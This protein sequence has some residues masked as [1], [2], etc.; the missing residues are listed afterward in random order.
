L[1]KSLAEQTFPDNAFELVY[2]D[3]LWE[4]REAEVKA[5]LMGSGLNWVYVRDKPT[6]PGPCPAGARNACVERSH[7]DWII[8]IDDLTYLPKDLIERHVA[9]M[10]EG[11]DAVCGS[12]LTLKEDA[13]SRHD[14][15]WERESIK[16][17]DLRVTGAGGA[18]E[19]SDQLIH[20]SWWGMH[21]GFSKSAW[22]V[23]NGFD[24]RFDG[25]YGMEDIDFGHRL[26]G[27]GMALAWCPELKV[28]CERGSRHV[29]THVQLLDSKRN[30]PTSWFRGVPVWRNDKLVYYNQALNVV[31]GA[32]EGMP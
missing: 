5:V 30:A 6:M 32:R 23:I 22:S 21:M 9:L 20:L 27:A 17:E 26:R 8:S 10:E 19:M 15:R 3:R 24:E 14:I 13:V 12:Y 29:D 4:S 31:R 7:G 16:N 18:A 2:G 1:L 25:V 11:F 28:L